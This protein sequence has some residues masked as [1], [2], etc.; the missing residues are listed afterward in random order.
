MRIRPISTAN[1]LV[2]QLRKKGHD[3]LKVGFLHQYVTARVFV[4]IFELHEILGKGRI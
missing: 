3:P 4:L 2:I 1:V